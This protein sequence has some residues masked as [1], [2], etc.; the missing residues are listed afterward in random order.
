[1]LTR[2]RTT[3]LFAL[4]VAVGCLIAGVSF[5]QTLFEDDFDD[6]EIDTAKWRIDEKAFET[7]GGNY[8]AVEAD[9]VL[10]ISG[11]STT[12]WWGGLAL[13]TIPTF[14]ASADS[15]RRADCSTS[16]IPSGPARSIPSSSHPGCSRP[17]FNSQVSRQSSA[18]STTHTQRIGSPRAAHAHPPAPQHRS[19]ARNST[20]IGLSS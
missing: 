12:N 9:G 14:T 8:E 2:R 18:M 20:L 15:P 13:S 6:D 16:F 5:G 4:A 1:M 19:I 10:T 3:P 7:G 17:W 11:V